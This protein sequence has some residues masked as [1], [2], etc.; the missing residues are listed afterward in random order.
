[1]HVPNE[2]PRFEHLKETLAWKLD[3]TPDF[4][5][6]LFVQQRVM[7]HILQH[8]ISS[9]PELSG[10]LR[11]ACL[12]ATS[13]PAT[14]SLSLT[15][16]KALERIGMFGSGSVNLLIATAVAEEGMDIPAANC[17]IRFD[18]V[19]NSVSFVQVILVSPPS[20][21]YLHAILRQPS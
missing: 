7:T 8:V 3:C 1:V 20:C 14:A 13:S 9:D 21:P 6:I 2:Y 5:G 19:L 18:P 17:I 16:S 10:R 4:R 11:T 15:R 12:Y